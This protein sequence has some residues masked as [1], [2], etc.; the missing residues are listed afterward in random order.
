MQFNYNSRI[1][2]KV[3]IKKKVFKFSL[4]L[5]AFLFVLIMLSK[6]NFPAPIQEIKKNI[7]NEIIKLK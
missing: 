2:S 6:F 4:Y 3:T 1:S 7:T 5:L